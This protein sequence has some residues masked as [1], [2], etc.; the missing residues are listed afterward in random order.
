MNNKGVEQWKTSITLPEI[1]VSNL[2]G[3]RYRG[4]KKVYEDGTSINVEPVSIRN[5][6]LHNAKSSYFDYQG[7]RYRVGHLVAEAW[8]P[9]PEKLDRVHYKDGDSQNCRVDNLEWSSFSMER[10]RSI[11]K[12]LDTVGYVRGRPVIC[13]E[14]QEIFVSMLHLSSVLEKNYDTVATNMRRK[15]QYKYKGKIYR[16]ATVEETENFYSKLQGR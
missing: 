13:D 4:Y 2:G 8:I 7:K 14:T 1:E 10:Q 15:G 9:N 3:V 5:S 6:D 12:N 11:Q 16:M